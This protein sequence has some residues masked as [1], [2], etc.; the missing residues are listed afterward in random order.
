MSINPDAAA[1]VTHKFGGSSLAGPDGFHRVADILCAR[2]E[3]DQL[4]V[5][6][7]MQGVTDSLIRLAERA[8]ARDEGWR[9]DADALRARHVEAARA[10]P[11]QRASAA[12]AWLEA[13]FEELTSLLQALALLG[14]AS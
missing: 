6:S 14:G 9:A 1:P 10:L 7:A 13:R 11:G 2:P 12:C 4:V 8:G 3:T 5:V